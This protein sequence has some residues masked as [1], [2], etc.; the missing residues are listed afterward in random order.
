ML[1]RHHWLIYFVAALG[2]SLTPGPNSLL[3]SPTARCT[4]GA[5][6]WPRWRAGRS[7]FWC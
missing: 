1:L 4:A 3:V 2:L 5:A 6:R 7:A